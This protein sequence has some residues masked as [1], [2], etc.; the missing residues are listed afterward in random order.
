MS[1]RSAGWRPNP[2]AL[3][4]QIAPAVSAAQ[5]FASTLATSTPYTPYSSLLALTWL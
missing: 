2:I 3:L 4:L 5:S 1:A